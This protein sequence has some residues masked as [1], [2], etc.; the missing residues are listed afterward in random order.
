MTENM[1]NANVC[2]AVWFFSSSCFVPFK[3]L[4]QDI[5]TNCLEQSL[6]TL[7]LEDANFDEAKRGCEDRNASLARISSDEEHSFI[8]GFFDGVGLSLDVWIGT[9]SK[10]DFP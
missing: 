7:V 8:N 1:G 10:D 3:A 2:C 5:L 9:N 6:F 4:S